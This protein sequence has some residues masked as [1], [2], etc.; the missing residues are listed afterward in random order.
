MRAYLLCALAL[1]LAAGIFC[2]VEY[3]AGLG[4]LAGALIFAT[5]LALTKKT[6]EAAGV[7]LSAVMTLPF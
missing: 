5:A 4:I 2:G 1:A 6:R 3:G 7:F